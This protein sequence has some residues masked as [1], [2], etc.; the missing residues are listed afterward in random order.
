M[1]LTITVYTALAA[2]AVALIT[3]G[4]ILASSSSS[5]LAP[6]FVSSYQA[7]ELTG[8]DCAH[9]GFGAPA[10]VVEPGLVGVKFARFHCSNSVEWTVRFFKTSDGD[11]VVRANR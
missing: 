5:T 9:G 4:S 2:L 7:G 8:L 1:K 11:V 10:Q 3:A 6:F